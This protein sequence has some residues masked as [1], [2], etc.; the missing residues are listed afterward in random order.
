M[1]AS[2]HPQRRD[3]LKTAAAGAAGAMGISALGFDKLFAQST[4][5]WVSGMQ[6]NPAI[7]NKRVI[8]CHDVNMLTGNPANTAFNSQNNAVNAN[9]VA[10]NLDQMAMQLAQKATAADAWSTIFRSS[11]PW[12]STNVAIKTNAIQGNTGNH[13]RVAIIKKL[14]DVFIDQLGVPAANLILYDAN[15]D[16]SATYSTYASL[17]DATKIRATVSKYAQSLGG[18]VPVTIAASTKNISAVGDL[19]N[20]VIDILVDICT[21]KVHSGPG[22]SYLFGSCSLCMKGHLGTF[23]NAGTDQT[24]PSSTGLH[25]LDA[26]CNI[27]K[28]AALLGGNPVRQQLCIVDGL[29]AN[30]GNSATWSV[31][32][33]RIVMG[34]FAP[35]VDYLTA[36]KLLLDSTIMATGPMPALGVTNAAIYLPQF[37]TNFGYATTDALQWVECTPPNWPAITGG[38]GGANGSGGAASGGTSATGGAR[39]GGTSGS[40]GAASGGT[41]GSGGTASGG[42]SGSGGVA[43]GGT[44]GSGGARSGGTGAAGNTASGGTSSSG[45]AG[46]GGT[47]ATGGTPDSGG[48]TSGGTGGA[49]GAATSSASASGGSP[50]TGGTGAGTGTGASATGGSSGTTGTKV[51]AAK[52]EGGCDVAGANRRP[53]RWGAMLAF[54]AV[55]AEKLRRLVSSDHRSS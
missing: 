7:D 19:V 37:L 4:G 46:S 25:S 39:S 30:G 11:K 43:S 49:G 41:S 29:L 42:A 14:C 9:Q 20:G 45:G 31:R 28:H 3:F 18:M 40:G 16:A 13:P 35:I 55:V 36:T 52:S 50:T 23:I 54:G 5:G 12:A 15:A 38:S 17:T 1:S 24:V 48:T 2:P 27:N 34:T 51:T 8:C 10:S 32:A 26:I 47:A 22:T 44:S 53:T 6:V 33:D 21:M